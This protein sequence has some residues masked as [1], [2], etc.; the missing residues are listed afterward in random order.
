[1]KTKRA[2]I[3]GINGF[4]A[5]H[6]AELLLDCGDI[7]VMGTYQNAKNLQIIKSIHSNIE[8]FQMDL[9]D[10]ASIKETLSHAKPDYIFHLAAQSSVVLS[11]QEPVSTFNVNV[12]GTLRL[13][14]TIRALSLRPIIQLACSSEQYGLVTQQQL[15][16][17]EETHF[18][19][20]SPYAVSRMTVDLIGYQYF[21][22]FGL[23]IIRTLAFNHTGPGQTEQ[24]VCSRFAKKIAEIEKGLYE[25]VLKVGNLD[26]VRDFTDVRDMVRAYMM[27]VTKGTPGE[28][29]IIASGIGRTIKEILNL[30][31]SLSKVHI[32]IET[33]PEFLRPLDAPALFGDSTKFH[34]ATGWKA[35]IPFEQ[36]MRD[37][38][39]Y[40]RKRV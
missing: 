6:L 34:R 26:A 7:T 10:P 40:W 27:S 28:A 32:Y 17:T 3:T 21:K 14:E 8:L 16:I 24:Y 25:P 31:L 11:W 39:E 1:M 22:N 36:T 19:P 37:L 29:Y 23:P 33:D 12:L 35:E 18:H 2:L 13:L 38:L 30:F 9:I 20:I 15:P 5:P 4:V